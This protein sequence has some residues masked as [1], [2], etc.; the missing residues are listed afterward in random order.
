[1]IRFVQKQVVVQQSVIRMAI[2]LP[3]N[4]EEGVW[5]R[6]DTESLLCS[7]LRAE[8][9]KINDQECSVA[10]QAKLGTRKVT[11]ASYS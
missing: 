2:P 11:R 1:M 10:R 9:A 5:M 3:S 8:S 6:P 7:Q 4:R